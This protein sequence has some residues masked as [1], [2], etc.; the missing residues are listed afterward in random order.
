[1]PEADREVAER[2]AAWDRALRDRDVTAVRDFLHDDYAL[3]LVQ[4]ERALMPREQWLATLPDYVVD[5]WDIQEQ[6]IAVEGDTAS[7]LQRVDMKATV[8][9]QDRSGIFVI[10]DTWLKREGIWRVW[11]RH[12]TPL[13]AG[14]VPAPPSAGSS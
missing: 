7:V 2:S 6:L 12:S 8:F 10:S 1:M 9:G 3:A 14:K 5:G 13:T 4:P 11:R